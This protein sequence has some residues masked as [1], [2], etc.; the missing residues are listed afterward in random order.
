M[1]R[2]L[3][4]LYLSK[5]GSDGLR[6]TAARARSAAEE[7]SREGTPVRFARGLQHRLGSGRLVEVEAHLVVGEEERPHVGRGFP[8][9]ASS[10]RSRSPPPT[11]RRRLRG[12]LEL[13]AGLLDLA[14]RR[15]DMP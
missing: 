10:R 14:E 1:A 6:E 7:L 13:P 9:S 12:R 5:T 15:V 2:Y 11:L 8:S 4:E 3:A